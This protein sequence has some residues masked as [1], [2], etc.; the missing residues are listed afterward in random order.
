MRIL[1]LALLLALPSLGFA[2]AQ[3]NLPAA[4]TIMSATR[5]ASNLTLTVRADRAFYDSIIQISSSGVTAGLPQWEKSAWAPGEQATWTF[6]LLKDL[7]SVSVTHDYYEGAGNHRTQTQNIFVPRPSTEATP[8]AAE[9]RLTVLAA[10]LTVDSLR[11]DVSNYGNGAA[12]NVLVSLEDK[13]ARKIGAPYARVLASVAVGGQASSTFTVSQDLTQAVVALTYANR[14]ERTSVV[15]SATAGGASAGDDANVTLSTEL[16]FREV[17]IGRTVDYPVTV[18]NGGKPSLVILSI[19]GLASGYSARFFVGGSAVPSLYLD[20][21]QSRQVTLSITVPNSPSEVDRT[22][23]FSTIAK[24]NATELARLPMGV[25][26]RGVG[27]LEIS[28]NGGE[29]ALPPGGE[30]QFSVTV[31]NTGSA[32]VFNIEFDSRRPYGWTVRAEPAR[33][34]R[35]DPDESQTSTITLRAPDIIGGGRY[36]VD[37][38]AKSG[39][40]ASRFTTLAVQVNE[41]SQSGGVLWFVFLVGIASIL[42]FGAWWKW[43]R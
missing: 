20:G 14:T 25:A 5:E 7:D 23:D 40:V 34:E 15:I 16:P 22:L 9:P 43:K 39:D 30:G 42:G 1:V 27:K 33:V 21:N 13:E 28:V 41:S 37:V 8:G 18:R 19:E 32:P 6:R 3:E 31:K 36:T 26:V 4:I 12:T 38:A 11:V 35:L 2:A 29:P 10:T 17:D 24:S